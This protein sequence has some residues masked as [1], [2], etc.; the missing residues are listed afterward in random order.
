MLIVYLREPERESPYVVGR[1]LSDP[2][3]GPS[4]FFGGILGTPMVL[5]L[6][7][8][9]IRRAVLIP[10]SMGLTPSLSFFIVIRGEPI[11]ACYL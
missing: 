3:T 8:Y 1:V 6:I 2:P 5:I 9:F 4:P 10:L 7:I 11:L